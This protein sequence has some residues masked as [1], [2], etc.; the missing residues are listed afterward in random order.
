MDG[1]HGMSDVTARPWMVSSAICGK[2]DTETVSIYHYPCDA[3][4]YE[5]VETG[6]KCGDE[7]LTEANARHIVH[8]VNNHERLVEALRNA[9]LAMEE[10]EE[11]IEGEWGASRDLEDIERDGDL[12]KEIIEARALLAELESQQ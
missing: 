5:V 12:S 10:Y 11:K 4:C 1:E 2:H 7:A 9:L 6:C 8:C 3:A